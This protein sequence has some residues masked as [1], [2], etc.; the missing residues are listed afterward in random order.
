MAENQNTPRVCTIIQARM[1]SARLPGKIMKEL[2]G[3][4]MLWHVVERAKKASMV[5]KTIVA[6]TTDLQ[7][8]AIQDLAEKEGWP[9]YRGSRDDVLDRYYQTAKVF[10]ADIIVRITADCPL[11]DPLVIDECIREFQLRKCDFLSNVL[12][13]K[14]TFP[15]GLDVRVCSFQALEEAAR[16]ATKPYER[17]H[18]AP[19]IW[20][21]KEGKFNICSVIEASP[22]YARNYRLTVDYPEDLTMMEKMYSALYKR[23]TIIDTKEAISFLDSHPEIV[24]I[25]IHCEQ[26]AFKQ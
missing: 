20:E 13:D 4:T 7:D 11:I 24:N 2:A 15:R 8:D 5:D 3:H 26:K 22:E 9:L 12:E 17:E 25:N 21:N 19:Y 14:S 10:K 18:V 1:A 6:T 16:N 23:G